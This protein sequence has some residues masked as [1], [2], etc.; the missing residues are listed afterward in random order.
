[1]ATTNTT[2]KKFI[3]IDGCDIPLEGEKNLLEVIRKA[4]IDLP[5]FCYNSDLSVYG[6]CR[7][8]IVDIQGR[9]INSSCSTPPEAGMVVKTNTAELRNI[10]KITI[11]L[12]LAN[13][14]NDCTTC[15]KSYDCKLLEI[16]RKLGVSEIR[17]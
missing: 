15:V 3:N 1:M 13:H 9:G 17:F 12:L 14:A 7:L 4:G 10:R 6:A 2:D 8:C 11:E 5:T 16:A